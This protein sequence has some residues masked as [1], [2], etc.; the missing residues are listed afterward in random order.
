MADTCPR[1]G[2]GEV[3]SD[4]CPQCGTVVATYQSSIN[5]MRPAPRP[6]GV[7]PFARGPVARPAASPDAPTPAAAPSAM[8]P[9]PSGFTPPPA[10]PVA[11]PAP[12]TTTGSRHP[13][14]RGS[15]ASLFGIHVVNALL[16]LAT[17]GVYYFWAK[18]RVRNYL[19]SESEFEGDRFAYHGTG[20]EMLIGFVKA[21]LFFFVPATLL[22]MLPELTGASVPVIVV[23]RMLVS[24]LA[25]I[26]IPVAIVGARRYR[27]SRT[28][29]RGIRFSFRGATREFA[30][31]WIRGWM[32]TSF[33][34]GFYYPAFVTNQHRFLTTHTWFGSQRFSFDGRGR[35]LIGVWL[36]SVLLFVP[37]LG[38]SWFW[39]A[40]KRQRYYAEHTRVAGARFRSTVTAPR[41]AWL[42]ISTWVGLICTV[43]L[44]WP[45]LTAR[46]VRRNFAWLSLDGPLALDSI[47]QQAQQVNATGEGLAGFFDA[48]LGFT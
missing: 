28:S 18:V 5:K 14:F 32:L 46:K 21:S 19:W 27:L 9:G 48:D 47:T 25:A 42:T 7:S 22:N 17:L 4:T 40:A 10:P 29:W 41:L 43:G 23:T 35:D 30:G 15:G 20:R 39:F 11:R 1:C 34:F 24:I 8:G 3:A 37:T 26:F 38:L 16:I 2:F 36:G 31:L 45:W 44:A 12:V 33:T 13:I 6:G